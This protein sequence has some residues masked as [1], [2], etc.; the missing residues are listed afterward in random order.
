[1]N[2]VEDNE[3]LSLSE[4][5]AETTSFDEDVEKIVMGEDGDRLLYRRRQTKAPVSKP[6]P[7][8]TKAPHTRPTKVCLIVHFIQLQQQAYPFS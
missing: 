4:L 6:T 1:M 2:I 8:P 3:I 7:R 5:D